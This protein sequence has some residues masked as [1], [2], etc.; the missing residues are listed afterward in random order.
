MCVN[1]GSKSVRKKRNTDVQ[2]HVE[3]TVLYL[4][5]LS[6]RG[7]SPGRHFT[8]ERHEYDCSL[9]AVTDSSRDIQTFSPYQ[10]LLS[11]V[12]HCAE[13]SLFGDA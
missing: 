11:E 6:A 3:L 7:P 1:V 8:R 9:L 2:I 13:M 4:Q 12:G 5:N 10:M